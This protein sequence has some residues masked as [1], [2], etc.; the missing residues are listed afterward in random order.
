LDPLI[1]NVFILIGCDGPEAMI[2][3]AGHATDDPTI[4]R[5]RSEHRGLG[6]D[7]AEDVDVGG[8]GGSVT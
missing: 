4:R 1:P 2:V 5:C 3:A 8:Y 6:S 7:I